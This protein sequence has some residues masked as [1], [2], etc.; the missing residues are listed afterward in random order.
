MTASTAFPRLR[1]LL[2]A[3][4][5]LSRLGLPLFIALL[6]LALAL[7][8]LKTALVLVGGSALLIFSLRYPQTGLYLLIPAIPFSSFLQVN[9]GGFSV[10][11]MEGA[12][13][14]MLGPWLLRMIARREIIIPHAPMLWPFLVFLGCIG[15][16]WLNAFSIGSAI[17]ETLKWIE[18]LAVYLFISANFSPAQSRWPVLVLL[19]TGLAQAGLGLYQFLF[20]IGPEGFLL[21]GGQFLRAYGSFRQPNPYAGYLG[22][23]LPLTLSLTLWSVDQIRLKFSR[24]ALAWLI[25]SAVTLGALLAALFASQSRGAW[26]GFA[27]AALIT[28]L[29]QGGR[30]TALTATG[31]ITGA[32]LVSMGALA[33]LPP[34]IS[35]R[36]TDVIPYAGVEDVSGVVVTDANFAAIERLAHWQAARQMWADHLWLGVG[37]GNYEA[38]YPAYA[39]GRWLDPLGHAHNYLLNLGAETGLVGVIG[40]FIFWLW[41]VAIIILSIIKSPVSSLHRAVL[42]GGLG[43]IC[44][45]H[46]HNF[47]DNLYVQGMY[48]HIAIIFGLIS[49]AKN[50]VAVVKDHQIY[51]NFDH[52]NE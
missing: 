1:L 17:P 46:I 25:L 33:F 23:L 44:H 22:L 27:V 48:L 52:R 10:G 9:L 26:V 30:W 37:F 41:V 36:F 2:P 15:L 18:M 43:I 4:E 5:G 47:F 45:L 49:L 42:V 14:L 21:F 11:P 28:V 24:S 31:L 34:E 38:I 3:K 51:V 20:K 50:E 7:L 29:A 6:G 13:A 40:Y 39:V 12:L 8:P 19:L 35:Q 32:I 16:S